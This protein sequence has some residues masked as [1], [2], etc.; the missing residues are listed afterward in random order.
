MIPERRFAR[1]VSLTD[2]A[3]ACGVA[4]STV[5]RALNNPGRVSAAMHDRI[6]SKA[7]EM[8]YASATLPE[9]PERRARGTIALVVPNLVNPFVHDLIRGSQAQCQAAG[10]LFLLVNTE[11]SAHVELTWLKELSH[12][13]DG[14][15]VSSPRSDDASLRSIADAVPLTVIN[16]SVEG[17]SSVVIDTPSSSVDALHYLV[18]LGHRRIAYVRGPERSWVSRGRV[19][20]V[21]E[22]AEAA[23]VELMPLGAFHPSL[24]A[25]AAA[26][27]AV[28]MSGATAALFFNDTLA[29]G[30]M[31]R[32][33]QRGVDVPGDISVI[34]CD[35]IASAETSNPPLTTITASGERAARA[36][37]ELLVGQFTARSPQPRAEKL[38]AHLTVRDSTGPAPDA[39]GAR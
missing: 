7:I 11:E 25:G 15:V 13:V 1:R 29:I 33:R 8:G 6:S 12:T 22:A 14:V 3:R 30:A 20:A 34:G 4:P 23:E 24:A 5:S 35:D 10:F 31:T 27:D 17:L 37:T 26:A 18:S 9:G 2:I 21:V 19:E 16:R 36:A 38:A 32:F 28:A 39:R